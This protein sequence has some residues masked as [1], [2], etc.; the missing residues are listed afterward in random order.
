MEYRMKYMYI[1]LF[2]FE[3]MDLRKEIGYSKYGH[4]KNIKKDV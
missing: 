4:E 2:T 3:V 1:V